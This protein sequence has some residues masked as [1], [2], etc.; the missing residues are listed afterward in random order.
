MQYRRKLSLARVADQH[1]FVL[2]AL[3]DEYLHHA[4]DGSTVPGKRVHDNPLQALRVIVTQS[5]RE[6]N[7]RIRNTRKIRMSYAKS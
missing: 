6:S 2:G 5:L 1:R 3:V 7:L 4:P